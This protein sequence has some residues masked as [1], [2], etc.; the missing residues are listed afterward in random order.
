M[1]RECECLSVGTSRRLPEGCLKELNIL[2]APKFSNRLS[3]PKITRGNFPGQPT[4]KLKLKF[5]ILRD[6][7]KR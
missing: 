2:I 3:K 6:G 4:T 5:E 1:R 7:S